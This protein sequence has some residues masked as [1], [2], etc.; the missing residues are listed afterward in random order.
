MYR[1][2]TTVLR[3]RDAAAGFTLIEML[4]VLVITAI[5]S[6]G[7]FQIL[8][9]GRRSHEI[10]K[11]EVDMQ[12][13]ARVAMSSI[14]DDFRHVSYGKDPTQPSVRYAGPDSIVFVA[15]LMPEVSGAE[16]ISYFLSTDGDPDTPN[17]NDTILMKE[18]ADSGGTVLY[19]QPQSYG[20]QR[21]GLTLRYFNGGGTELEN[22][23]PHPEL[24][25]EMLCEVTAAA[26]ATWK[27]QPYSTMNLSSTVYPRNLP[28]S[29]AR[30]RPSTP[31]GGTPTFPS[32]GSV[33]M[34]W[35]TP[36]TNTDETDLPLAEISHFNFYL[37][38][39][40]DHMDLNARLDRTV[41]TWT[42]NNLDCEDYW[43]SIT[44]VSR[45]GVESY[46][47]E[48]QIS[49]AGGTAPR[50]PAT[51]AVEDSSGVQV[52]WSSV[53]RYEDGSLITIPVHYNVYRGT[54]SGVTPD[55]ANRLAI[56]NAPTTSYHDVVP[57]SC[58]TYYYIVTA[59]VCCTESDPT[60]EAMIDR[61]SPPQCP[62]DFVG[63]SG[64]VS[65]E[66]T[67]SWTHPT[68][69]EDLT[70]IS[71]GEISETRVYYD[72][73]PGNTTQ[74]VVLEGNGTSATLTGLEGCKTYYVH[75][76]TIDLCGHISG[77]SCLGQDVP[78]MMLDPCDPGAPAAPTTL[79]A[80]GLDERVDLT[81]AA[82]QA[83]CDLRGYRIYYG[84]SPGVY[85]GTGA[86]Q[87]IS[88]IEV[89]AE[90]VT[91]GNVCAISLTG[92]EACQTY[93]LAVSTI[94]RCT[95]SN[96][97]SLTAASAPTVC[98][99][100][101]IGTGCASWI[102]VPSLHRD[103]HLE[104]FTSSGANET[105]AKLMLTY[106]GT[107]RVTQVSF[108]RPLTAIWKS[109]GTAG[110]DGNIGPQGSGA[111]LNVS[112]VVVESWTTYTDGLPL[113][114]YFDG[115]VRDI[116]FE[117]RFKNPSGGFCTTNGTN[118]A[119]AVYDDFDDGNYTGW[120]VRSG[121]WTVNN[122]ELYQSS[123]T[124]NRMMVGSDVLTNITYEAKIKI[125]SGKEAYLVYRYVDDNNFYM[126]GIRS[127]TDLVKLTRT[128]TGT[129]T[130]TGSYSKPIANN[131]WYN[132]KVV[133]SGT[134][135]RI[136]IDCVQVLDV[137]DALMNATGKIGFR[138][139]ATAAKWDDARCQSAAML[140]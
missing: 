92:L 5:V 28:L 43:I 94:D 15:D 117:V 67:L 20:I 24:I 99:S 121:T 44:C 88:P 102:S 97:S 12:Q 113:A 118:R 51:I 111:V 36:T 21:G 57:T 16:V 95:P 108:G 27:Q 25:G 89:T 98:V 42:V 83:D 86:L 127:D 72:T 35:A 107:P 133:L 4:I 106:N 11:I 91:S 82:N 53:T 46:P 100:C 76:R 29:P 63:A 68:L 84:T 10:Q 132:L 1:R 138:T 48:R 131:T 119:G 55:E 41:N 116:P 61:P 69:R 59:Q 123:T 17:P 40:Q 80:T 114:V 79:T 139:Q 125:T 6:A 18:V 33:T 56:V 38:I 14:T 19:S 31:A 47:C 85:N 8:H 124:N 7:L 120:T 37:G 115:D 22:P 96:E 34:T 66:M 23:V 26:G 110:Q 136:Y 137:T 104:V 3:G 60:T 122:G 54:S 90:T 87:G 128:R 112:D 2:F 129:A 30:S 101:Q 103:T 73:L 32:C 126:V 135:S 65:G 9:A 93:Y 74:Y 64:T 58:A 13:N 49:V 134:R 78:I 45:S 81:W 39:N 75:G 105:L 77:T 109:D 52:D 140:P 62:R 71:L 130:T 70:P 50:A